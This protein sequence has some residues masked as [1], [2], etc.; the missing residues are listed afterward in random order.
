[1]IYPTNDAKTKKATHTTLPSQFITHPPTHDLGKN[2]TG[3]LQ[4]LIRRH[5][6]NSWFSLN[7]PS[8]YLA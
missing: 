7:T 4:P 5:V 1:M 6:T 8:W 2:E 3:F